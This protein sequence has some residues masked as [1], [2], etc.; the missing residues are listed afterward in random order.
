MKLGSMVFRTGASLVVLISLGGCGGGGGS[1]S[2]PGIPAATHD[3]ATLSLSTSNMAEVAAQTHAVLTSLRD[4]G[5]NLAPLLDGVSPASPTWQVNCSSGG[6]WSFSYIDA[7][8][9]GTRSVGDRIVMT[10]P[11]CSIAPFG[12]GSATATVLA[13][14]RGNLVDVRIVADGGTLP[15]MVGWNWLPTLVGTFRMTVDGQDLWL[16]S[17]GELVFTASA[18]KAFRTKNLGLR[19]RD[20]LTN[21]PQA[22]GILGSL[23]IAF[24]TPAGAG[25]LANIDT[26]GLIA[27]HSNN[28]APYP[29]YFVIQGGGR[30]KVR[31]AD[32]RPTDQGSFLIAIDADGNG[33][34]EASTVV[35]FL[36]IF[37]LL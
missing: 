11:G 8:A 30:S 19:L 14:D 25:G 36:N 9:S 20:D 23:D 16:R 12:D 32:A 37:G 13:V 15:Y 24:D 2:S 35:S 22:P 5:Y 28:V 18:N 1:G 26:N 31:V 29:G 6:N 3:V 27:G 34:E 17:E 4:L 7:D 10:A 21:N 33:I